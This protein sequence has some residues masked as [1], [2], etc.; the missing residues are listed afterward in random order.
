MHNS[1]VSS[2]IVHE[3]KVLPVPFTDL[4]DLAAAKV[5]GLALVANDE[6]FAA[7]ENLLSADTPVFITDKYTDRG[8]WMDGWESRRS[9]KPGYDWCI[10]QL[11]IPGQIKGF[12]VY[13]AFFRGNYP[14]HC[15]IEVCEADGNPDVDTLLSPETKWVEIVPTSRLIGDDH[16]YFAVSS[17]QRWTHV[18]LNIYPDGGVARFRVHGTALP[19]FSSLDEGQTIEL[20][21][22]ANGGQVLLCN[23][24]FFSPKEN[25]ILP[26][27]AANMG[28]GW[29]TRRRREPGHD[30]VIL[31]LGA[32][33]QIR[34][35][36]IDT[37]HFK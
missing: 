6:F 36:E 3:P 14:E 24:N 34:Q 22:I 16:N 31:K 18:R 30:W 26:G 25:L 20:S 27:K 11:G 1:P 8:K 5:G 17:S 23:D 33:G 4:P 28:E 2:V 35:I 15:S 29:E 32:A 12:D 37:A 9:R 21:G 10:I 7:K 13:T 19:D